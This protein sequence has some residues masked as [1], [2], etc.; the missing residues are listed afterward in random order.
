MVDQRHDMAELLKLHGHSQRLWLSPRTLI[1]DPGRAC[2]DE[3]DGDR[4]IDAA[5]GEATMIVPRRRFLAQ[6][7]AGF[8]AAFAARLAVAQS[9]TKVRLTAG[10]NIGYSHQYVGEAAG[11]FRKHG[12]D[13]SVLLFDV[14]FLGTEAVVAGQAETAGTVEFPLLTLLSKGA[15][16]VVPAVI[17]TADDLK[18]VA[19]K[20]IEKAADF[21]GKR[22]G[23]IFGSSA[24]Y[25]F[26]RYLIHFGVARDRVTHVNVPA[27]EQVALMARGD[28]DA[29]VWLEPMVSRGIEVMRGRAH[30]MAPGI[31]VAYKTRTYLEMSRGWVERNPDATV[32]LL[33]GFIE[34]DAFVRAEPRRTAEIAG[35][36]LNIPAEQ[37]GDLLR[38]VGFDFSIYLDG[39]LARA[40]AD[41]ADWMRA[42]NRLPGAAPDMSKVFVPRYLREIDPARV[43]NFPA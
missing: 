20:S 25:A 10:A 37:A 4:A 42:Q 18:I 31:E 19:L 23:Y 27:A 36:K 29:Y 6:A 3:G 14:G 28:I 32:G 33:R 43:T 9:L 39:G 35:R 41:V 5:R 16:L 34:A 15:D 22:V 1:P 38:K 30:V 17:I 13:A 2:K 21:A 7:G 24:H 40:F 12:I 11:I 26:D 8:G